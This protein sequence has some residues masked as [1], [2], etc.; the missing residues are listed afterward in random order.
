MNILNGL[1]LHMQLR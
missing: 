1:H